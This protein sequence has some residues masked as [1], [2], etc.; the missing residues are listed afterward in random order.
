MVY[1]MKE[2]L[3]VDDSTTLLV[4]L[5]CY[6][7]DFAGQIGADCCFRWLANQEKEKLQI[8]IN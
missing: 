8:F 1:H 2:P 7:K 4:L 3:T 5:S 6:M